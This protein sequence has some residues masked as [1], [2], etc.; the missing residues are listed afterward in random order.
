MYVMWVGVI[1][2]ICGNVIL[3][4]GYGLGGAALATSIAYVLN[5]AL[6]LVV[7][8]HFSGN[9]WKDALILKLEDI[10]SLKTSGQK[11]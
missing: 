6:R 7:Y 11:T 2:N 4:P 3:I 5:L 10:Q 8:K 9:K 1:V